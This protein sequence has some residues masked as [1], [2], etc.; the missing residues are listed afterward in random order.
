M[1]ITGAFAF[2]P[3]MGNAGAFA[4][5]PSLLGATDPQLNMPGGFLG[6]QALAPGSYVQP[7][8]M[9]GSGYGIQSQ[10][11]QLAAP[12]VKEMGMLAHGSHT[13]KS[14]VDG[15][16]K[17]F[18]GSH[19]PKDHNPLVDPAGNFIPGTAKPDSEI[20]LSLGPTNIPGS[21]VGNMAGLSE[22]MAGQSAAKKEAYIRA[23]EGEKMPNDPIKWFNSRKI[24][25]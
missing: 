18:E 11:N 25:A 23:L 2:D 10:F 12:P 1:N 21:S 13:T 24:R 16:P 19:N 8:N 3:G 22:T 9:S 6:P 20:P 17:Y 4:L 15:V 7:N 14:F 5:P